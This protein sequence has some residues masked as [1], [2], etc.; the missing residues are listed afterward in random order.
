MDTYRIRRLHHKILNVLCK[1][2]LLR[3]QGRGQVV[4]PRSAPDQPKKVLVAFEAIDV[5]GA[6]LFWEEMVF[7][8]IDLISDFVI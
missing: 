4:G 7:Y 5:V 3:P 2:G 8:I 1:V 6:H